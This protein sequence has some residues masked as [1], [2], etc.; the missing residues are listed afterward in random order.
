MKRGAWG[1]WRGPWGA[2]AWGEGV[3]RKES[4]ARLGLVIWRNN[5]P[6]AGRLPAPSLGGSLDK[7]TPLKFRETLFC[8]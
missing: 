7:T 2:K 8:K 3:R 1:V 5:C 6:S 4:A